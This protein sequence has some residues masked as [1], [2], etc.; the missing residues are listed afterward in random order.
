MQHP[1]HAHVESLWKQFCVKGNIPEVIA[2]YLYRLD[3][4]ISNVG[5]VWNINFIKLSVKVVYKSQV[6]CWWFFLG[7]LK[8]DKIIRKSLNC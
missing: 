4:S 2:F 8:L 5:N 1:H 3:V 6:R 7:F